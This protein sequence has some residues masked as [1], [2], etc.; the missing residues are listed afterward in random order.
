MPAGFTGLSADGCF[1]F[2]SVVFLTVLFLFAAAVVVGLGV[3]D[4]A[5]AKRVL[6][7]LKTL[8]LDAIFGV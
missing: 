7:P 6:Q 8:A 2:F 5:A 3:A 4:F 1:G